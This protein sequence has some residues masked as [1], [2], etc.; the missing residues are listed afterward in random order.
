MAHGFVV[1]RTMDYGIL[2]DAKHAKLL[3]C[4]WVMWHIIDIETARVEQN[5]HVYANMSLRSGIDAFLSRSSVSDEELEC[6]YMAY[7]YAFTALCEVVNSSVCG[8]RA[9]LSTV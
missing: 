5:S 6:Y 4:I 7:V 2:V 3:H 8:V 9:N 1:L